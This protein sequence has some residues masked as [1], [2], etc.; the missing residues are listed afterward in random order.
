MKSKAL[1]KR[2]LFRPSLNETFTNLEV[3][4]EPQALSQVSAFLGVFFTENGTYGRNRA[5]WRSVWHLGPKTPNSP[6]VAVP[7]CTYNPPRKDTVYW[8][9]SPSLIV[10]NTTSSGSQNHEL[11]RVRSPA[12]YLAPCVMWSTAHSTHSR[13]TVGEV[14]RHHVRSSPQNFNAAKKTL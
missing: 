5:F 2:K 4:E 11:L 12:W 13:H 6:P 8:L 7:T 14:K 1:A 10:L 3:L 9:K